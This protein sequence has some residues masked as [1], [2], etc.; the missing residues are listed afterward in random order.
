MWKIWLTI[1]FCIILN[2]CVLRIQTIPY[3]NSVETEEPTEE[4]LLLLSFKDSGIILEAFQKIGCSMFDVAGFLNEYGEGDIDGFCE[5]LT[6]Q[7][8]FTTKHSWWLER[9]IFLPSLTS[10]V[11]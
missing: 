9:E 6:K 10:P 7:H 4:E 8:P 11:L 5:Y 3:E 1:C 2:S